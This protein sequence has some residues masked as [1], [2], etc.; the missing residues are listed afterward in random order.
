VLDQPPCT[1]SVAF[2]SQ[3]RLGR[4]LHELLGKLRTGWIVEDDGTLIIRCQ[5]A[6]PL[7]SV[8]TSAVNGTTAGNAAFIKKRDSAP[9]PLKPDRILAKVVPG[10]AAVIPPAT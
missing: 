7:L 5:L 1:G 4:D 6:N 10:I 8:R 2:R 9:K 3:R